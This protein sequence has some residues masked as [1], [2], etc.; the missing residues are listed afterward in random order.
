MRQ[1]RVRGSSRSGGMRTRCSGAT[2]VKH[3]MA[4]ARGIWLVPGSCQLHV[5]MG[6]CESVLTICPG[7]C[8]HCADRCMGWPISSRARQ[9][10]C[11]LSRRRVAGSVTWALAQLGKARVQGYQCSE[12]RSEDH[13]RSEIFDVAAIARSGGVHAYSPRPLYALL[14]T[15]HLMTRARTARERAS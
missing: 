13:P 3:R 7:C 1:R 10:V 15:S 14:R 2:E 6:C 12:S 11:S 8:A 9:G 4:P 5:E